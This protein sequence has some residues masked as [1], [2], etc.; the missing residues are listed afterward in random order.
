MAVVS[1]SMQPLDAFTNRMSWG[2]LGAGDSG[3]PAQVWAYP[4][5]T[6]S[7]TGA[8]DNVADKGYPIIDIFGSIEDPTSLCWGPLFTITPPPDM[9][10]RL[11]DPIIRLDAHPRVCSIK[12][13]ARPGS[14]LNT[15]GI[16]I[17]AARPW[18]FRS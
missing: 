17:L 9:F 1:L 15:V 4:Y 7:C 2:P 5:L 14:N 12:P 3:E 8:P 13:I 10:Y 6:M 16:L 18:G 11:N